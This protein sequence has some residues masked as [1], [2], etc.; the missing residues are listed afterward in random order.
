MVVNRIGDVG[1]VIAIAICYTQYKSLKYGI[2]LNV[3]AFGQIGEVDLIGYMLLLG[4]I[5]KSAQIG[6]HV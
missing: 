5:G 3:A 1:I 4:A 2:I 6:L